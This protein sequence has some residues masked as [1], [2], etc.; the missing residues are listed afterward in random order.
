MT[1]LLV[2]VTEHDPVVHWLPNPRLQQIFS[3][4]LVVHH[5]INGYTLTFEC[6]GKNHIRESYSF[7]H[8][9]FHLESLLQRFFSDGT[10]TISELTVHPRLHCYQLSLDNIVQYNFFLFGS[11]AYKEEILYHHIENWITKKVSFCT[12]YPS[13]EK[14]EQET[15]K[16]LRK[17]LDCGDLLPP[18]YL[19]VLSSNGTGMAFFSMGGNTEAIP[20]LSITN[21]YSTII[22]G[23]DKR[24]HNERTPY[25]LSIHYYHYLVC[26][27][28]QHPSGNVVMMVELSMMREEWERIWNAV[29]QWI[30][31]TN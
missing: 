14:A 19:D 17:Q 28:L 23:L 6:L 27:Y 20:I 10:Y 16:K 12:P 3:S 4:W 11:L 15:L 30:E 5:K 9:L 24:I 22:Q 7:E 26:A 2:Q 8:L 18:T 13:E 21:V 31:K 1:E 29:R 25:Q